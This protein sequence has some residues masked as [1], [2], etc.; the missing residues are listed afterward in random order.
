MIRITKS[1]TEK[2]LVVNPGS[3]IFG[4]SVYVCKSNECINNAF[5]KGRL[6]KLLKTRYD[7]DLEEGLRAKINSMVQFKP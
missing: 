7:K 3:K 4:R 6:F 2:E 1:R 5:K